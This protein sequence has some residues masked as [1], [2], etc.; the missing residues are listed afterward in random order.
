M[1]GGGHHD[2][3]H[4]APSLPHT[5][6]LANK[7][8]LC[9]PDFHYARGASISIEKRR[10]TSLHLERGIAS[11]RNHAR[12]AVT[13]RLYCAMRLM[14]AKTLTQLSCWIAEV[15]Y[16]HGGFYPDPKGWRGNLALAFGCVA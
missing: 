8:G 9:P 15:W 3:H 6:I 2:H 1:G 12:I 11:A 10:R 4:H 16:P 13:C 14:V 7:S 5:R